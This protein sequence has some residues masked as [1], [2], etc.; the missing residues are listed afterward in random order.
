MKCKTSTILIS[1][2]LILSSCDTTTTTTMQSSEL[3]TKVNQGKP[4]ANKI[5]KTLTIHGDDRVDNYYWLNQRENPEVL[6]YLKAENAYAKNMLS[7]TEKLQSDLYDE[8]VGRIKKD[9]TS[10]P[11]FDNGYYYARRYEKDNEY[12]IYMRGKKKSGDEEVILD[13]NE[14]AV[15]HAFHSLSGIT[16]S[17]NNKL[18]LFG[19]DTLSRRIY[20]L[21]IK[22]LETGEFLADQ[23]PG[24]SGNAVWANDNKT[25]FYTIKDESLRPHKVYRHTIGTDIKDDVLIFHEDDETFYSYVFRSTSD[26]Y[27]MIGSESTLSSEIQFLDAD[28]PTDDFT[29]FQPRERDLEYEIDHLGDHFYVLTNLAAKNFQLMRTPIGATT[30]ENWETVIAHRPE[31]FIEDFDVFNKYLVTTERHDGIS[32]VRVIPFEGQE[33][34]VKFDDESYAVWTSSNNDMDSDELRL[35][36]SSMATPVSTYDF[37]MKTNSLTLLKQEEVLGDFDPENYTTKLLTCKA[38]DGKSVPISLVYQK[39]TKIDGNQPIFIEG[40]GSYGSTY[41]PYFSSNRLTLLDRGFVVAIAHIRGG[42]ELGRLW[43]EDGKLL[44]KK[45]TFTD[46]IDVA[47]YLVQNKYA[48]SDKVFA[49]GGSAGGLLMGAIANMRPDLWAGIISAVPFVDVVTTM[50]DE[51]IPLTT[52]EYDEWGNPN[53]KEYYDYIKSYS[54]YD[55]IE[56]KDYPPMLITTGLHDSQVQYWE[57][58][59]YVA[60]LRELKTDN[61]PLLFDTNLEAGHG[62][63]SGRF[64]RLKE[65]AQRYAFVLDLAKN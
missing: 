39:D 31:V 63:A 5:P 7:H 30:K 8:M 52:G 9:D 47:E 32:Q 44:K 29:V 41:D 19:E 43:Y 48:A 6:E 59:K 42:Q 56:A 28:R 35:G 50:L 60:K 26:K 20:N 3:Y 15:G 33:F 65:I 49:Y 17:P 34:F 4:S 55:N 25:I 1:L 54:P 23:I 27:V 61:N 37:N 45:N 40:Y 36:Y 53:D 18:V 64:A 57:P 10:V 24:T 16:V 21:R 51:S 58:A 11:Y 13:Q 38:R 62:G 14:L 22:N 2:S 46:F 12:P